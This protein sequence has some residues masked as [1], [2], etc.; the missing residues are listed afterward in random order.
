MRDPREGIPSQRVTGDPRSAQRPG[1]EPSAAPDAGPLAHVT[2]SP[3]FVDA[4]GR[5]RTWVTWALGLLAVACGCYAVLLGLS[6]LG[7]PLTPGDLLPLPDSGGS[8]RQPEEAGVPTRGLAT[9]GPGAGPPRTSR[10]A[11]SSGVEGATQDHVRPQGGPARQVRPS[12]RPTA[13]VAPTASGPAAGSAA[14]GSATNGAAAT[15]GTS[16][17]VPSP[18]AT[19][20]VTPPAA[21]SAV[22]TVGLTSPLV[23]LASPTLSGSSGGS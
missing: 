19:S 13:A 4:S 3:V 6:F 21:P 18:S 1:Q 11:Q 14:A 10:S 5:R 16:S 2:R 8:S 23:R 22:P 12:G 9:G 17:G 15:T 20:A 7:G